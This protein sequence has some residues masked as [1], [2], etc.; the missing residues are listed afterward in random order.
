MTSCQ[1]VAFMAHMPRLTRSVALTERLWSTLEQM[2]EDMGV[3]VDGLLNQAVFTLARFH[4]YATPRLSDEPPAKSEEPP[5]QVL[6]EAPAQPVEPGSFADPR[7]VELRGHWDGPSLR[8]QVQLVDVTGTVVTAVDL[9]E[10]VNEA[11]LTHVMIDELR[12]AGF[13]LRQ[14]QQ[15]A[16]QHKIGAATLALAR[17]VGAGTGAPMLQSWL[18]AHALPRAEDA[19]VTRATSLEA[20]LQRM[21]S[22]GASTEARAAYVLEELLQGANAAAALRELAIDQDQ[23]S[24]AKVAADLIRCCKALDPAK[25]SSYA[26]THALIEMSLGRTDAVRVALDELAA[27]DAQQASV[28]RPYF[29]ALYPV[30][31]FWPQHDGLTDFI[32][33]PKP[34]PPVR[35]VATLRVA[36]QKAATRVMTLRDV[37]KDLAP[38]ASWLPPDLKELLPK[39]PLPLVGH[40]ELQLE[41]WQQ[42]SL[43]QLLRRVRGEW[44]GLCWLCWLG[45]LDAVG[46]PGKGNKP[47]SSTALRYSLELRQMV[48]ELKL[49]NEDITEHLEG[50]TLADAQQVSAVD[51]LGATMGELPT[52]TAEVALD[53]LKAA[54][55]PVL[56]ADES[57][58]ISPWTPETPDAGASQLGSDDIS[59]EGPSDEGPPPDVRQRAEEHTSPLT[60]LQLNPRHQ[61]W[62]EREGH[63]VVHLSGQKRFVIGRERTCDVVLLSPRV[64]REHAEILFDDT[65]VILNDLNSS[66]GTFF[67]GERITARE[68]SDGDEVTFGNEAVRFHLS[69]P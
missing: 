5:L 62:L 29:A 39:G 8:G 50:A 46:L 37:L 40:D 58:R 3:D 7:I 36:V 59:N 43:P 22:E 55:L 10:R 16:G 20:T 67:E 68:L 42:R 27:D 52:A 54:L 60:A 47:R 44:A 32:L 35:D 17:S 56:W 21:H 33:G 19:G 6:S 15:L 65:G 57:H 2:S 34:A 41:P 26:F 51:V 9:G 38:K 31:D 13:W 12:D 64:S 61:L 30:Y 24:N 66:N 63:E 14:H 53:E 11:D 45:G 48:L 49:T 18:K 1:A 69:A 23:F 25:K 4:G 28:L